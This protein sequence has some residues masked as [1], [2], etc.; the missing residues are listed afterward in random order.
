MDHEFDGDWPTLFDA[1]GPR[2]RA[3][4]L[5]DP[6]A[7]DSGVI[8]LVA[9]PAGVDAARDTNR[10]APGFLLVSVFCDVEAV[11]GRLAERALAQDVRRISAYGE[12]A[13]ATVRD[14][15]GV[16]VELVESSTAHVPATGAG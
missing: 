16:L 4:F 12:V 1:P 3:I 7:P 15:N 10:P 13:M 5:G 2:L 9:F 8:E 11:L 6:S 14:P